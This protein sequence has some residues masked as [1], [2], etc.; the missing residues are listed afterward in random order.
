MLCYLGCSATPTYGQASS[1]QYGSKEDLSISLLAVFHI[2]TRDT[3][4]YRRH[5]WRYECTIL[6]HKNTYN[7]KICAINLYTKPG[8]I[9]FPMSSAVAMLCSGCRRV[10]FVGVSSITYIMFLPSRLRTFLAL[11][12]KISFVNS[13]SSSPYISLSSLQWQ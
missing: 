1:H 10:D 5:V 6:G 13:P 4:D 11:C 12:C 8:V 9:V 3:Y 2:G 7:R